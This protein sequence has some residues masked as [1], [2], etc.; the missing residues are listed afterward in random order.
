MGFRNK[1][2]WEINNKKVYMAG[3][4]FSEADINQRLLEFDRLEAAGKNWGLDLD[5]FTPIKAPQNDKSLLPT[6]ED[7][8]VGDEEELMVAGVVFADLADQD[9]G[10]MMEL[11]MVIHKDTKIYPYLSDIRIGTSG[12]Y[13]GNR[14]PFGYNQF[15]IGGLEIYGNKVYPSFNDALDAFIEEHEIV[16]EK[17]KNKRSY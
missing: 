7:I 5:I 3:K 4:L 17:K 12:K 15:V 13:E 1:K 16:I 10:V 6:S 11:G 9:P 14:I 2:E 8:F